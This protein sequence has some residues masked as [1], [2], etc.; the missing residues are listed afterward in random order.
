LKKST[1]MKKT[2]TIIVI[3]FF[4]MIVSCRFEDGPLISFRTTFGRLYGIWEVEYFEINGIDHTQ[5]YKDSCNYDFHFIYYSYNRLIF[6][7][8]QNTISSADVGFKK[9]EKNIIFI[10]MEG[11]IKY[12]LFGNSYLS[13]WEVKKLTNKKFWLKST[14]NDYDNSKIYYIEL[15]KIKDEN[16]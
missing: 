12:E 10:Y 4:A 14:Y 5:E 8:N 9:G 16:I 2:I 15:K 3:S 1:E 6:E 7:K 13:Y 11:G